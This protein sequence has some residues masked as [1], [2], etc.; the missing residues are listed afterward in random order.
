MFPKARRRAEG[1]GME[2]IQE[3]GREK[4]QES[5]SNHLNGCG[6][7]D[8]LITFSPSQENNI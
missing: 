1:R 5:S 7:S 2:K 6:A 8:S 4:I 3:R